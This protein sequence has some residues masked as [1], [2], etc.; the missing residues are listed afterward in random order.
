L[1]FEAIDTVLPVQ[2]VVS[3]AAIEEVVAGAAN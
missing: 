2:R 3:V 1:T